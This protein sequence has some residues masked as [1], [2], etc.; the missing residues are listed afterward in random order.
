LPKRGGRLSF[1]LK[2]EEKECIILYGFLKGFEMELRP[3][4][5]VLLRELETVVFEHLSIGEVE[6][7]ISIPKKPGG[8]L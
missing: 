5:T 6:A 3:E 1:S 2:I 4:L 8:G 7:L